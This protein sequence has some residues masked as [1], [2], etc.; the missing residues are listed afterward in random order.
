MMITFIRLLLAF[1]CGMDLLIMFGVF[2]TK[3]GVL[4]KLVI[5]FFAC[6]AEHFGYKWY[7][8]VYHRLDVISIDNQIS[9]LIE[10]IPIFL[11]HISIVLFLMLYRKKGENLH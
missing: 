4:R 5:L 2:F 6:L 3:D 9:L 10:I 11:A 7:Y 1:I 8:L